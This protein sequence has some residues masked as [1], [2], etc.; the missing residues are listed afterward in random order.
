M[1]VPLPAPTQTAMRHELAEAVAMIVKG[2][3]SRSYLAQPWVIA[4]LIERACELGAREHLM[5][6][7]NVLWFVARVHSLRN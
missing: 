5:P 4:L 6:L 3:R 7:R 2:A 1:S